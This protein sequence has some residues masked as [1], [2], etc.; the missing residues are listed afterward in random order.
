MALVSVVIVLGFFFLDRLPVDLL[1]EINYPQIRVTVNYPGT[2]PEVM[3]EQITRVLE[4]SLA[5][6]ENLIS[7][8]SRASEG[9]TNV[10]LI[11]EYGTN[12]DLALQDAS[13]NLEL[14]RTRM[15]SDI[16]PPRIYKF[17]PA[18]DPIYVAGFTSTIRTPIEV[19][20][21]LENNLVPQ[22]LSVH[23]VGGVEVA[24]GMV[25][26]IQVIADQDRLT[27]YSLTM[28][29][30]VDALAS[31]NR[32][33]AAGQVTSSTFDVMA[34]TDARFRSVEDIELV[35]IQLPGNNSRIPLSEVAAIRDTHREQRMFVRLNGSA[36]AQLSVSKLPGANTVQIVDNVTSTLHRLEQT[37]FIP[38]DIEYQSTRDSSYF[39]RSSIRAV[40]TAA[41]LGSVLAMLIVMLFLGS[42]RKSFV[43]GLSI[44]IAIMA[45]FTMMGLGNLTL[46]IMSLGGL[47][48][49]VGLLLDNSIVM[50]EN[51]FR[52]REQLGKKAEEA[53]HTGSKEVSSAITA[54]TLTNLAAVLPFLLIVGITSLLFREL[55]LTISFAIIASLVTALTL[56][57][58]LAT[59]LSRI[60]FKSGFTDSR[61]IGWFNKGLFKLTGYYRRALTTAIRFRVVVVAGAVLLFGF[62]LMVFGN[63]GNE[64]LPQVDDGA[65]SVTVILPPGTTPE[66]TNRISLIVEEQFE[67]MPYIESTF[68]LIGGH[69]SGGIINER[70][71]TARWTVQLVPGSKR[72]SMPAGVWVDDLQNRLDRLELAGARV[73]VSPP[74]IQGVR[75]NISG[76]DIS[77]SI[78][79]DELSVLD[80][81]GR[82]LVE[83][84]G[85]IHG[86]SRLE[87]SRQDRSPL[88][89]IR[90]DRERAAA[91][92]LRVAEIGEAIRYAVHGSVPTRYSAGRT[93]YD[94]RVM[95]P[96]E[97]ASDPEALGNIILFRREGKPVRLNEVAYFSLGDGPAHIEREN[98]VRMVR[99]SGDVNSA[100]SDPGTVNAGIRNRLAS[101]DMP[102][103]YNVIL[104][105][106]EE[107][108]RETNRSMIISALL[109]VFMV[110]VVLAVQY[111]RLANPIVI[112]AAVPFALIGSGV[113]LWVTGTNLS[114]PVLLGGILLIGIVVNNAI[115]L[116]EY[117]E[118][119]RRNDNL[120]AEAAAIAAGSVRFRPILMTT[121]TTVFGMLP[122]AIG[123]GEGSELMQ[124]LAV[125]V[126]GGLLFSTLLTLFV[127]PCLYIII[128]GSGERLKEWITG[129][130]EESTTGKEASQTK[131]NGEP[132]KKEIPITA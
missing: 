108:I 49:G 102:E 105:G 47:A 82:E 38:P 42:L 15:P 14:A 62:A 19:R 93:E 64:F 117:I 69:L 92:G 125:T 35:M 122:L 112:L 70:P 21:W 130:V 57:P 26:E 43:I 85:N 22:L 109:A 118:K 20:D 31:E 41:I 12:I 96:R 5:A 25:R 94:V 86:I 61:F 59:V 119:G 1:P 66:E 55:I 121:M 9:R 60:K 110:F 6:T 72:R 27:Y 113:L 83:H 23:G 114:A 103:G 40:S 97:Y 58:M 128:T 106:N 7:L 3:E 8:E 34:K 89:S 76:A 71:A 79:G 91:L 129:Q 39:I 16:E 78:V 90:V 36:A 10:N 84:L 73:F 132:V 131:D 99:I 68:A 4:T 95:L 37:G 77:L 11:F 127:V 80:R 46:N 75:T 81:T 88:L 48:L 53:A 115:L 107:V 101:F 116:V 45:T 44:P 65:I 98:Q 18:Q 123:M 63:L 104:G 87:L 13:R 100:L 111:E 30:L 24:G 67:H 17:D 32:D 51:I 52:H 126:V 124:P 50:L 74:R 28:T 33:I 54:A 29:D 120:T 2:A 56:V